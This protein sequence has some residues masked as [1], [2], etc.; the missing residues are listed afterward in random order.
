VLPCGSEPVLVPDELHL[1]VE[2]CSHAAMW[3]QNCGGSASLLRRAAPV[4]PRPRG[5]EPLVTPELCIPNEVG[6][7]PMV[8]PLL[9]VPAE[10]D[11]H[12][13]MWLLD[14][15]HYVDSFGIN[16]III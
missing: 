15:L 2:A 8:T 7:E 9:H 12:V 4:P 3:L 13:A 10:S 5:S 6:S 11:S 14:H 16:D 1:F